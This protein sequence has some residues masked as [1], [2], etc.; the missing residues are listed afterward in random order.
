MASVLKRG[1]RLCLF[2]STTPTNRPP[3]AQQS[4]PF[5]VSCAVSPAARQAKRC[6]GAQRCGGATTACSVAWSAGL[7][8]SLGIVTTN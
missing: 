6:A 4:P 7:C 3:C 8:A 1:S 2:L 5:R